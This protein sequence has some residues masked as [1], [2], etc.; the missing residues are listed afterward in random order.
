MR[1]KSRWD[2][3]C[4]ELYKKK[5]D[6]PEVIEDH[7]ELEIEPPPLLIE[8]QTACNQ[9][10]NGKS[11]GIDNTSGELWKMAGERGGVF[12]MWHG[13]FVGKYGIRWNGQ[14]TGAEQLS[15][16]QKRAI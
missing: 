2:E 15:H 7:Q 16:Y 11:P 6:E 5:P 3:Y 10:K 8:V 14:G 9:L 13:S 4:S 12:I 1:I